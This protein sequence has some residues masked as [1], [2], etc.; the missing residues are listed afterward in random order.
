MEKCSIKGDSAFTLIELLVVV[1][2]IGILAAVALPQYQKAVAKS[3]F[4]SI[5]PIAKSIKDAQEI[6][7]E[8]YGQYATTSNL[9]ELD[10]DY[11]ADTDVE[12][13][14]TDGH[15]YVSVGHDKLNNRYTMYLAHSD[16]FAN[17]IYCEAQA[18]NTIAESVCEADG[19]E[20]TGLT[21]GDYKLYLLSGT[22]TGG[23]GAQWHVWAGSD[24]CLGGGTECSDHHDFTESSSCSGDGGDCSN[25]RFSGNGSG[26]SSLS[27]SSCQDNEFSG[28]NSYCLGGSVGGC[29]HNVFSGEGSYCMPGYGIGGSSCDDNVFQAGTYCDTTD[30]PGCER[31]VFEEGSWCEGNF[32][33]AGS[34]KKEGGVW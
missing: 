18:N 22:S 10:I 28:A 15:E 8:T 14:E 7:F 34:P 12:L 9:S 5:K 17:N 33:P 1:L 24:E 3:R 27:G 16:N 2:I 23:F 32:C 19:G 25:N 21:N 29:S 13:S 20:D 31:S 11:P 26:C 30:G 6:Y 4:A